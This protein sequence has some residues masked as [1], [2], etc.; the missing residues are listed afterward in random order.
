MFKYIQGK[1]QS[2][3]LVLL[4]KL[5]FIVGVKTIINNVFDVNV[6]YIILLGKEVS[7]FS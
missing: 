5:G 1:R 4:K 6:V 3:G 2:F 7:Y